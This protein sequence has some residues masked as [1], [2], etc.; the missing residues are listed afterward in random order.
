MK[1]TPSAPL[2]F[3]RLV[4]AA[5]VLFLSVAAPATTYY[6]STSGSNSNDGLSTSSPWRSIQYAANHMQAGD[7]VQVL[8]G[9]YHETINIPISG[10]ATSGYVTFRNRDRSRSLMAPA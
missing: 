9:I 3:A 2:A 1:N 6:V 5:I 10:S 4:V 7:T 8:A